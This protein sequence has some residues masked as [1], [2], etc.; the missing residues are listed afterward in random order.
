MPLQWWYSYLE[1]Y[2]FPFDSLVIWFWEKHWGKFRFQIWHH[3]PLGLSDKLTNF[4]CQCSWSLWPH[5]VPFSATPCLRKALRDFLQIW[6][7]IDDWFALFELLIAIW[8]KQDICWCHLTSFLRFYRPNSEFQKILLP[9]FSLSDSV[10]P[11][12]NRDMILLS[13]CPRPAWST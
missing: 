3:Y 1:T 6:D 2:S 11:Y 5:G 7:N 9:I 12:D 4:W 13:L 8:I 10:K